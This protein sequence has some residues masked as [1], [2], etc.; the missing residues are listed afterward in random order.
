VNLIID[1]AS[2]LSP[3]VPA[4]QEAVS[5]V[6]VGSLT[7]SSTQHL[8]QYVVACSV[9]IPSNAATGAQD[10]VIQFPGT[11]YTLPGAFLVQ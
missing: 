9:F 6:T 8:S 1:L 4:A 5:S 10:V 3:T 7:A 2:N 11:S